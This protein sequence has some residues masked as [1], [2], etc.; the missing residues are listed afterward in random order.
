LLDL[1]TYYASLR[2]PFSGAM[3]TPDTEH[4][5]TRHLIE[6]GNPIRSIASC[7]ACHGPLGLTPGAPALR[8]QQRAYLEL[9]MQ[10]FKSGDRHNDI[11]EQMRSVAR[12]LT[13]NEIAMLAAYYASLAD[14]TTGQ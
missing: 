5:G 12:Q 14:Q 2:N 7:T 1:A 13:Q 11:S 8:G 9:E 3:K 6:Y 4:A 10:K